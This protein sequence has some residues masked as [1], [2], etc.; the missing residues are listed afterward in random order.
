MVRKML[1]QV[2]QSPETNAGFKAA[3]NQEDLLFYW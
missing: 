2:K 1:S 3:A